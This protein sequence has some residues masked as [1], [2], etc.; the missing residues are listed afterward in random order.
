[1]TPADPAAS[2]E[3]VAT[4]SVTIPVTK[5]DPSK[6]LLPVFEQK[7]PSQIVTYTSKYVDKISDVTNSLNI[8]GA[9]SIKYGAVS[10]DLSGSYVDSDTFQNSDMNFLITVKVTNQTIN[11]KDQLAFWPLNSDRD[12]ALSS[13]E[14]TSKY[15]DCFISGFQ[16]GGQFSA[17]VS[18]TALDQS[19]KL[20]VKG[21][22]HLALQVGVGDIE[23]SAE[24]AMNKEELNKNSQVD[25]SVNWSGGGQLKEGSE[26][27]TID[28]L[29][30]VAVR[31]PDLVASCPQRTHA[32]LTKYTAL[33]G[34]LE[35]QAQNN[36]M[37]LN[38]EMSN[39]YTDE[40]LD[41]Y[42]GYK[43]IWEN[44]HSELQALDSQT[45]ELQPAPVPAKPINTPSVQQADGTWST[46]TA[47]TPFDA[48]Y[49]GLDSA[50]QHCRSLMA[51]IVQEVPFDLNH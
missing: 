26:K 36:L 46:A 14:F 2:T 9:L 49:S 35:W 20:E 45:L 38:Y 11:V 17:L 39:L 31:F 43:A 29:T 41:V 16:E 25:I 23:G 37:P 21:A 18:I 51:G 22:A 47:L 34:Y 50:L 10:G 40:L 24:I 15:G 7:Y 28:T 6:T 32:I 3:V 19:K 1:M 13:S 8:S 27:W 44:L 4:T 30:E 5:V 42:M 48:D 33:R 12:K